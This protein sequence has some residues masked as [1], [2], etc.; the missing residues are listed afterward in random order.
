[1]ANAAFFVRSS[2]VAMS[3][4]AG[5]STASTNAFT[6]FVVGYLRLAVLE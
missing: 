3:V 5:A 2:H 6:C 4:T 1:L